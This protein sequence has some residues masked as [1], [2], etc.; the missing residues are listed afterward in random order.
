MNEVA[1]E[2]SLSGCL[3]LHVK[4]VIPGRGLSKGGG[5]GVE[6]WGVGGWIQSRPLGISLHLETEDL[7]QSL[8][9]QM[10]QELKGHT[11]PTDK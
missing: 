10:S 7:N 1:F 9:P 5:G 4:K 2:W 11:N 8:H 6:G 3:G